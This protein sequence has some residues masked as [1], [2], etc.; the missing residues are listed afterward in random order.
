[1]AVYSDSTIIHFDYSKTSK[2]KQDNCLAW[3]LQQAKDPQDEIV[4][5]LHTTSQVGHVM[6][7]DQAT[8]LL[9]DARGSTNAVSNFYSDLHEVAAYAPDVI[10]NFVSL[11]VQ[12]RLS[13]AALPGFHLSHV[14][15]HQFAGVSSV[16]DKSSTDY[17]TTDSHV[18]SW[19]DA[20]GDDACD[21]EKSELSQIGDDAMTVQAWFKAHDRGDPALNDMPPEVSAAFDRLTSNDAT[22]KIIE[23]SDGT[24]TRD[25]LKKFISNL[26]KAAD[27]ASSSYKDFKKANP[28][29]DNVAKEEAVEASVLQANMPVLDNAGA[30]SKTD[31]SF[32]VDDLKALSQDDNKGLSQALRGAASFF[33][34]AGEAR[35]VSEAALNPSQVSNGGINNASLA[36]WLKND[37]SKSESDTIASMKSAAMEQLAKDS[38]G[39]ADNVTPDYFQGKGSNASAADKVAAYLQL[40]QTIGR[41]NAGVNYFRQKSPDDL[42]SADEYHNYYDGP[43]PGE[44]RSDFIKDVQSKISALSQD[45][46]V[47]SF[48]SDHLSDTLQSMVSSDPN[49]KAVIQNRLDTTSSSSAL[50]GAFTDTANQ[51]SS[52]NSY[53]T[54]TKALGTFLA[55]PNFYAQMLGTTPDLSSALNSASSSVQQQ[56]KDN[57]EDIVSGKHMDSLIQSGK[58]SQEALIQTALDKTVYDSVLD[59]QTVQDG[60]DRFTDAANKYSREDL[61]SGLSGDDMIKDLGFSGVDD[62]AFQAYIEKNLDSLSPAGSDQASASDILSMVRKVSDLLR[63]GLKFDD[64]MAKASDS[65]SAEKG[66]IPD[67]YKKGVFHGASA[68]LLAG[69]MGARLGTGDKGSAATNAQQALQTAGL[70]TEGGAKASPQMYSSLADRVKGDQGAYDNLKSMQELPSFSAEQ[71]EQLAKYQS[72]RDQLNNFK[73]L[74]KDAE[75]V[76]KSI[77]GVTGSVMGLVLGAIGAKDAAKNGD[78][79]GAAAQGV[80]A[81]MNGISAISGAGEVATYLLPRLGLTASMDSL[82]GVFGA[83][84]GAAGALAGIGSLIYAIIEEIKMENKIAKEEKAW[85]GELQDGFKP[86]GS[87][88]PSMGDLL[89]PDNGTLPADD[90]PNV[91]TYG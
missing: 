73:N 29:A 2:E 85:Y 63:Q 34:N 69:A 67:V 11:P 36:A 32:N 15:N 30:A 3:A 47:Q 78:K 70:L 45:S 49:M 76:G 23:T 16:S 56:V 65:W 72:E 60:T 50:D 22:K 17:T 68:L 82:A 10:R 44:K 19:L 52:A 51:D 88:L 5:F 26:D 37:T 21:E 66:S 64:A 25:T 61:T 33:S 13:L 27:N 57:Y 71:A 38:G 77:G 7:R 43:T 24:V 46:D 42:S 90:S 55:K 1:M 14:A 20:L 39:N 28:S 79:G 80:F 62:P 9:H 81:G 86:S 4:F 89:S 87:E 75:N 40:S 84:G 59:S 41:L 53:D 6:L 58:S 35:I 31:D 83:V 48:L 12:E 8:R 91:G 18:H 54:T 74:S